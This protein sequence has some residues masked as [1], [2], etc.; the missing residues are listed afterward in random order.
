VIQLLPKCHHFSEPVVTGARRKSKRVARFPNRLA[1]NKNEPV[2]FRFLRLG[3]MVD[4]TSE[5]AVYD[6]VSLAPWIRASPSS[7]T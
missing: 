6:E 2:E 3:R 4:S 1:F 7:C 5:T